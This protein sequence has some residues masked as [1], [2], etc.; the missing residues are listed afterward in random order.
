MNHFLFGFALVYGA[1]APKRKLYSECNQLVV[2]VSKLYGE[3]QAGPLTGIVG[4]LGN[5]F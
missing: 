4:Y 5:R 2:A 1:P 3:L